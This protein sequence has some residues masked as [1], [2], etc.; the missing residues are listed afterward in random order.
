MCLFFLKLS[1]FFLF[2][3]SSSKRHRSGGHFSGYHG[4]TRNDCP[5]RHHA[6][7]GKIQVH[8]ENHISPWT[9][10]SDAGGRVFDLH[11]AG[12]LLPVP[13]EMLNGCFEAGARAERL[14]QVSIWGQHTTRLLQQRPLRSR[15]LIRV[16]YSTHKTEFMCFNIMT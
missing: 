8:A 12:C 16:F 4:R 7:A 2:A 9:N 14:H 1:P 15:G 11:G 6:K 13:S 5:P 3:E 10:S